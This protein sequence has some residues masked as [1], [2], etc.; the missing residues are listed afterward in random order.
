MR[1]LEAQLIRNDEATNLPANAAVLYVGDFNEDG[2]TEAAYQTMTAAKSPGGVSQGAGIDPLN[3]T[4]NYNLTWGSSNVGILT[5]KDT[6][7]EYRDDLQLMTGNVYNGSSGTLEYVSG[8]LHAFGNN[9]SVGYESNINSSSNTAV[10]DIVGNGS[11]T[12]RGVL[13]AMNASLAAT[14]C[15][16]SPTTRFPRSQRDLGGWRR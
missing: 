7:L 4:N 9:G 15:R 13:S 5:E 16:S 14:I 11:L 6:S 1:N 2:S 8:S 12:V 3:P 10:N